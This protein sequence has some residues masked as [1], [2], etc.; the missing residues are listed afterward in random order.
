MKKVIISSVLIILLSAS[1]YSQ[2]ENKDE[3][4]TLFG[5]YH[6][7]GFYGA[8]TIG[9]SEIDQKQAVVFGGRFEWVVSHSVG[10]GFGGSGFLNE[11]HYDATLNQ[12][13]FLTGGY[14]GFYVEPIVMPNFPVHIAF[15][16][17]LGAGGVSYVT[18]EM[19]DYHNM[20]EDTEAFLIAEPGAE[21]E[22]NLT[23]NFRLAM[24]VSY[25][26]TTPFDVGATGSIPVSSK[27]I[28]GWTYMMTFK[29]GRF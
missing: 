3:F 20:I 21:L 16:V 1:I 15:P 9:Y 2:D 26:F 28:E 5:D 12:D 22:L 8:F 19:Q 27:S 4:K 23:R 29:F 11:Y 18:R 6:P 25:R 24:G 13:V 10:I 17:L 7:R 14:G